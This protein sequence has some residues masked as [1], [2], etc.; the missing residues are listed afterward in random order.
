MSPTRSKILDLR[1]AL[2]PYELIELLDDEVKRN[3]RFI[4]ELRLHI[5]KQATDLME[6]QT[7]DEIYPEGVSGVESLPIYIKRS[8][9]VWRRKVGL[10]VRK[11]ISYYQNNWAWFIDICG[12]RI[13]MTNEF[14][15]VSSEQDGIFNV[16]WNTFFTQNA[17][18][19]YAKSKWKTLPTNEIWTEMAKDVGSYLNLR[20]ILQLPLV[21]D[22]RVEWVDD[23][24]GTNY[25]SAGRGDHLFVTKKDC[26]IHNDWLLDFGR[27]LRLLDI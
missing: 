18:F 12:K 27:S 15:P 26:Q 22:F 17:A 20:K 3:P 4:H 21:W 19:G 5:S 6:M 10:T 23:I 24:F 9:E 14:V 1:E 2:L 8:C 25:W 16:D 13:S 7:S 11:N